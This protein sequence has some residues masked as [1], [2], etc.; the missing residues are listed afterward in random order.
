MK[1]AETGTIL[2]GN[3]IEGSMGD[4]PYAIKIKMGRLYVSNLGRKCWK[5]IDV[6]EIF[7]QFMTVS[8]AE[9]PRLQGRLAAS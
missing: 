2:K 5:N 8:P 1:K 7:M 4:G 6:L 3:I 9:S